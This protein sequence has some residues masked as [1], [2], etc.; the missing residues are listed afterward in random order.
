ML[1]DGSFKAMVHSMRPSARVP[2]KKD[3]VTTM[4]AV[5]TA[6]IEKVSRLIKGE[7]VCITTD[8][9]TSCANDTYMLLTVTLT[10]SVWQLVNLSVD[11]SKSEG[12]TSGEALPAGTKATLAKHGLTGNVTVVTTDCEASMVKMGRPLEEDAVCTHIGCCNHRIESTTSIVFNGPGVKK[13]MALARGLVTRYTASSQAADRLKQFVKTYLNVDNKRVIQD[14]ATRW[15]STCS[16]IARLLELETQTLLVGRKYVTS[17]L[18]VPFIYDLRNSLEDAIEDLNDLP[19]SSDA[20][21]STAKAAVMPC[22]NALRDDFIKRWG[23]GS[24]ILIYTEGPRRKPC[25]FKPVQLLATAL[26]P[27]T[28]ILYG[29]AKDKKADVWKLVQEE[30]VKIALESRNAETAQRASSQ[31]GPEAAAGPASRTTSAGAQDSSSTRRRRGGGGF[32]AAAQAVGAARTQQLDEGTDISTT[33]LIKNSVRVELTAFKASTGIK[34]YEEDKEGT[35][36]YLDP[37]DWWRVRCTDYPH[38]ANLAR[39]VLA[40]PATQAESERL[41]SCAGNIVTKN[42]NNLAPTTVEL[43]V[44]LRH[45]W[46]IVEEWKA[47]NNAAAA[48]RG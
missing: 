45:S 1:A 31:Q 24:D 3:C 5:K 8:G 38:L 28:K 40:I 6:M 2:E 14:V 19:P 9:W 16:M 43:L 46:K 48:K 20:D 12:T 44:L 13:V 11:C 36:V 7:H 21:V 4:R 15:W 33:S 17:S 22:I 42:R 41:F 25:G 34:M 26:D 10:S 18:V 35:R 32:M 47:S 27:R 29:V 23:D 37:L 30:A 39:R